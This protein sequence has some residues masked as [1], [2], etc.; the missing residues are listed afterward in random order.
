ML[1]LIYVNKLLLL[2]EK[3]VEILNLVRKKSHV[4]VDNIYV[5]VQWLP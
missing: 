3:K 1:V 4:E 5:S 2:F